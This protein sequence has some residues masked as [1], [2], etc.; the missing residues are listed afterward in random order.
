MAKQSRLDAIR[1]MAVKHLS[2]QRLDIDQQVMKGFQMQAITQDQAQLAEIAKRTGE[3]TLDLIRQTAQVIKLA[4]DRG[5][6]LADQAQELAERAVSELKVAEARIVS[7]EEQLRCAEACALEAE[8]AL[9]R[10]H[11]EIEQTLVDH[12]LAAPL[13]IMSSRAA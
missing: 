5:Q 2:R 11:H 8:N 1:T 10:V 12:R 6:A 9:Q 13:S 3:N 4:E 7:L